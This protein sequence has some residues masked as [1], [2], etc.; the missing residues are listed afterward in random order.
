MSKLPI[1]LPARVS[2]G[3]PVSADWANSIR[4][5]IARLANRKTPKKKGGGGGASEIQPWDIYEMTGT[6]TPVS[7][8]YPNYDCRVWPG[9]ISSMM[10]TNMMSVITVPK[11]L[12]Y[13]KAECTSTDGKRITLVEIVA[14]GTPPVSQSPR[15]SLAPASFEILFAVTLD[16][17]AYRAIGDGNPTAAPHIALVT[18]KA[19]P[20]SPGMPAQDLWYIWS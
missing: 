11:D 8:V 14:D 18:D 7:G 16:G 5:A 15:I 20:P 10:P 19:S 17:R 3:Q 6:G 1:N 2:S 9:S 13:W 12:T 4:E